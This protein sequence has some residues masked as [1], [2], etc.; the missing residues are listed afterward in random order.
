ME[1]VIEIQNFLPHRA[2]MLMVDL[3][4]DMDQEKVAT[5]FTIEDDNIF[6]DNGLL[7]EF[8][9]IENAA[10][11]CS[12]IVARS[13]FTGEADDEVRNAGVIGF[14]S[15]IKTV[16]I[17]SLPPVGSTIDTTATLISRFDT[18][19]YVTCMMSCK[20]YYNGQLLLEGD[21]NLF[22]QETGQ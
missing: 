5:V 21:I 17:H 11:T 4:V 2:P 14:I 6:L 7:S 1:N 8:G 20:S 16:K 15:A 13:Y 19:L 12:A 9:L 3:I 10:Q 18:G 22:I